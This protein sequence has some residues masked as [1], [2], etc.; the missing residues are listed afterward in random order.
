VI[1]LGIEGTAHTLG[2][3]IVDVE[4]NVLANVNKTYVPEEGGIHPREASWYI[5]DQFSSALKEALEAAK[6]GRE[7][8]DIVSFSKGPGLGP[9]LTNTAVGARALALS[10]GKPLVGVNHCVAHIEVGNMIARREFPDWGQPLTLYV[11]GANTQIIMFKDG[12]YRVF[13]ETLDI[14]LGNMLDKFGRQ[15]GLGH[16]AGPKIDKLAQEGRNYIDLPYVV[17]GNDLSYSGLLTEAIK[18]LQGNRMEDVCYSLQ[19]TAFAMT[20][21][22]A[23]RALCHLKSGSLLLTG[24]V[25]NNSRLREMVGIM[26]K[27][28]GVMYSVPK[29]LCGDNGAM[30][31]WTGLVMHENGVRTGLEES[32]IDPGYRT[33]QVEISWAKPG[34]SM[35]ALPQGIW[36]G[37]EAIIMRE[38]EQVS[39]E[40]MK[41]E[42]RLE[43]I[44]DRIRKSRTRKEP[45]LLAAARSAGIS[46]PEVKKVMAEEYKFFM[47]FISGEPLCTIIEEEAHYAE[48]MGRL[49]RRL[50]DANIIH[51]DLTTSNIIVKDRR[52][53]FIDFGLGGISRKAEDKATD[54]LLL[55]KAL[56][57]NHSSMFKE[58]WDVV[59]SAYGESEVLARLE[60][61]EKRGRYL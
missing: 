7:D 36:R 21:E 55:K 5:A 50:H 39:K 19:E 51:G 18:K 4:G 58:L 30:I 3:G 53:F 2:M 12:R 40:R 1:S 42:Y 56:N 34:S 52:L 47:E 13:G 11:S 6:M 23:E 43:Q 16:P 9:C 17:K 10:L 45:K 26:A 25:A 48:D 60:T 38:G 33:D 37:A 22:A 44:D 46:T 41:K 27:D 59:I 15:A 61:A 20:I 49:V 57:A 31:A 29:G 54:L 35:G 14:G 28:N 32:A 8:I 24:G